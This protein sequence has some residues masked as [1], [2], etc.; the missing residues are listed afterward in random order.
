M[1]KYILLFCTAALL[2]TLSACDDGNVYNDGFT[3]YKKASDI[4]SANSNTTTDT[5]NLL[6]V[7][8]TKTYDGV[9]YQLEWTCHFEDGK[10]VKSVIT[11]TAPDGTV[12]TQDITE[13]FAGYSKSQ[14]KSIMEAFEKEEDAYLTLSTNELSFSA[15]QNKEAVTVSTNQSFTVQI[16]GEDKEEVDWLSVSPSS[17]TGSATL[18]VYVSENAGAARTANVIIHVNGR[19]SATL[20]VKQEAG[21]GSN[22]VLN[23]SY[24]GWSKATVHGTT[25]KSD[26]ETLSMTQNVDGTVNLFYNS[27]TWGTATLQNVT[28]T[29]KDLGY[30]FEKPITVSVNDAQTDWIFPENVDYISMLQRG[31]GSTE[32]TKDYPLVLNA[33]YVS[34][35]MKTYEF[36]F[37]IYLKLNGAGIY[38]VVFK[39]GPIEADDSSA[40]PLGLCPDANH[41]HAIDLGLG[42]KWACCNVG[43]SSPVDYGGY[44]AWGET[45]TKS[46]YDW[47]TY[48]WCNGSSNSMTKYCIKSFY[49]TVDNQT[50]LEL[51][52]DAAHVNWGGSWRMPT[53]DELSELNNNCTWTGMT[54]EGVNGYKVTASNGNSIF[55][56]AAGYRS[57]EGFFEMGSGGSYWSS[58]LDVLSSSNSA[59]I[60]FYS[61]G[62]GGAFRCYGHSVRPVMKMATT[63]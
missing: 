21:E 60:L 63:R 2:F 59:R 14:M 62:T 31:P 33:G 23:S 61:G 8:F 39:N 11:K 50:Q 37:S 49:G 6:V 40:D 5:D 26:D 15:G 45:S 1:K 55:L 54:I 41:P 52:D 16:N 28:I 56:P 30:T 34:T 19:L 48:K 25:I 9:E 29:Y 7:N 57:G 27:P 24:S 47:S 53:I 38:D 43:S 22:Q 32:V 36:S 10:L 58:S 51:S 35:D 44:Y 46:N 4:S 17:Y 13:Q 3:V 20:V 12:E 18:T 42:V